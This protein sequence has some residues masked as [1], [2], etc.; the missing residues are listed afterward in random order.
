MALFSAWDWDRNSY[1][2]YQTSD[3]VSVG[4]DPKPPKPESRGMLGAVPD[5]DVKALPPG[6]RF[7]GHSHQ[8]RG[9]IVRLPA[10][11]LG[12]LGE[13]AE[14][15]GVSALALAAA[16]AIGMGIGMWIGKRSVRS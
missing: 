1:R 2:V 15:G 11:G 10:L 3:P 13:V 9:E 4:D 16:L 14:V 8:A 6:A 5:L 7:V 12:R